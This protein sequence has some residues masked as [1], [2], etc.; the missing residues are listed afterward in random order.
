LTID[1][2]LY[3]FLVAGSGSKRI[4]AWNRT[5]RSLQVL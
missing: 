4:P 5:H 2:S 1:L 3:P